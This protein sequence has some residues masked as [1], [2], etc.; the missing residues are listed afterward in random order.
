[1]HGG[2]GRGGGRGLKRDRNDDVQ[3]IRVA[4]RVFV[5]NLSWH[6]SWQ[7]LKDH[8]GQ[9]GTVIYA[10]VLKGQDERSKVRIGVYLRMMRAKSLKRRF[11]S[12]GTPRN[13]SPKFSQGCG[14]V[15][16]SEPEAA[17][18]AI[19]TL[20]DTEVRSGACPPEQSHGHPRRELGV[21][22]SNPP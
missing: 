20:T 8:F 10:D 16:F 2:R 3:T 5:G 21:T 15:E 22:V 9:A 19:Q 4:R 17:A 1:M 11:C 7:D 14:I 12:D 18:N 13:H 6:T